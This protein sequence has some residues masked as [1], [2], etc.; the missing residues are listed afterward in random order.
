[1]VHIKKESL[2]VK[3][4]ES[5]RW[6]ADKMFLEGMESAE[7]LYQNGKSNLHIGQLE[8]LVVGRLIVQR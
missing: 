8:C 2:K 4:R 5:Y 7:H 1:M 3:E 6:I